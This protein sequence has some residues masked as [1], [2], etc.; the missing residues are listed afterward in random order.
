M[1]VIFEIEVS[2]Q[3]LTFVNKTE[4]PRELHILYIYLGQGYIFHIFFDPQGLK[5]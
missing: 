5:V 3:T 1:G 4:R 2:V